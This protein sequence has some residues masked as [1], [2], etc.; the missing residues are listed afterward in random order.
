M[1]S[2]HVAGAAALVRQA[3]PTWS[4]AYIKSALMSTSKYLGIYLSDGVTPAQPLDMGAGRLDLTHVTDPGVIL[5]PPSLSYGQ[6]MTGTTAVM[7]VTLT[8]VATQTETYTLSTLYTGDGFGSLKELPG[9]TVSPTLVV[10]TPGASATVRVEFDPAA[11]Q[12]IGDNQGFIVMDGDVH[13]AHMPVW[14]RVIPGPAAADVLIIQNDFSYLLG[15][16]DYLSYYTDALDELGLTYD[17]WNADW[18]FANPT[19]IPDA[20]TLSAYKAVIYFTGDNY[21][22]DGTFTVATP[23]TEL[24]M[25]RLTE[26]AN[27]GGVV[28][29]M[30][31]DLASVLNSAAYDDNTFFYSYILGGNYYQDSVTH[32]DAPTLPVVPMTDAPQAFQSVW[33][34]LS[35]PE[36]YVGVATLTPDAVV[37]YNLYLPLVTKGV[38][39]YRN[40]GVMAAASDP[41]GTGSFGYDTASQ[42]L[43]YE[44]QID[45]T[46][47]LTITQICIGRGAAG[48]TGSVL[49]IVL[50]EPT[51]VT[52]TLSVNGSLLLSNDDQDLLMAGSLYVQ[53]RSASNPLPEL[54]GQISVHPV[55][56][57]A[58]NQYYIDEIETLPYREPDN[59]WY[60][61][62]YQP[63]L[64]YPGTYNVEDGVVAMAHRDQ[65]SLERAGISYYG[66]SIYTTFGLEG[67]NNGVA[68]T[69]REDLLGLFLDWAW[70]EPMVTITATESVTESAM[71]LFEAAV[72]SNITD[73]VGVRYRWDFGDGSD[74]MGPYASN[75]ASHVYQTCGTYTV[76]VEATDSLGNRAVGVRE[77]NVTACLNP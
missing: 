71:T 4:N 22:P 19:T 21:Y 53:V 30:G 1:A 60:E 63:L 12:G 66:R 52:D 56:D 33:L 70:D 6:V 59:E 16:P 27:G 15:F 50:S 28:I 39:T 24:D 10:L 18:Y 61:Y 73:V 62:P 8:S 26:Y 77:V 29:A 25:D 20:A 75:Q 54:R 45:V 14:A 35:E 46:N 17:V 5:D 72:T 2:P 48:E 69:S 38:S 42:R 34:D 3:H 74:Y 67:I 23:L 49:E 37:T 41:S 51:V 43:D 44:I 58:A 40:S 47:T 13:E 7:S 57:G 68:A 65:P 76:R 31:Q 36:N 32:Y 55:G 64:K 9:F 11:S